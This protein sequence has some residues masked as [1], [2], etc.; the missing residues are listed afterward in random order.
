MIMYDIS[1]D[2]FNQSGDM[3]YMG[4]DKFENEESVTLANQL[5][6]H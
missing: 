3:L 5:D 4:K 2:H 6:L 1:A